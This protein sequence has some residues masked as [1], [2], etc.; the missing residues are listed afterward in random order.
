[1]QRTAS[2]LH[3]RRKAGRFLGLKVLLLQSLSGPQKPGNEG[4][5][6]RSLMLR[7]GRTDEGLEAL[8]AAGAA[9]VVAQAICSREQDDGGGFIRLALRLMDA[10]RRVMLQASRHEVVRHDAV[11]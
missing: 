8:A 5:A 9:A 10:D 1:M 3:G 11:H 4:A 7:V 6:A 2:W